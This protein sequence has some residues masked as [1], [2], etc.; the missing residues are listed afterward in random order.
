MQ[1]HMNVLLTHSTYVAMSIATPYTV[2]VCTT[3]QGVPQ[4]SK[5]ALSLQAFPLANKSVTKAT[6]QQ[7]WVDVLLQ[8]AYSNMYV[9]SSCL[10]MLVK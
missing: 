7:S 2:V 10:H 9:C 6:N 1:D 4:V 5:S 8:Y 3:V